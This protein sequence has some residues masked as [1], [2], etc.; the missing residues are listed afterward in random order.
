MKTLVLVMMLISSSAVGVIGCAAKQPI[1][2]AVPGQTSTLDGEVYRGLCDV[3]AVIDTYKT[4]VANGS[5]VATPAMATQMT[6][7][8]ALYN[9][10]HTAWLVYHSA[11]ASV[12]ASTAAALQT[13]YSNLQTQYQAA[14]TNGAPVPATAPTTGA[15]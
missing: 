9:D 11:T 14:L 1:A 13:Q 15:K 5:F 3:Q 10:T 12:Q 4:A 6:T 7:L 2:I 8:I